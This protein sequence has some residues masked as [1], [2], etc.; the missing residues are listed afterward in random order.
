MEKTPAN[1][2]RPLDDLGSLMEE[3]HVSDMG[4]DA[5]KLTALRK[6]NDSFVVEESGPHAAPDFNAESAADFN[7]ESEP[8]R[9]YR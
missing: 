4:E 5:A 1:S 9:R 8:V 3:T 2:R 7:V 6:G